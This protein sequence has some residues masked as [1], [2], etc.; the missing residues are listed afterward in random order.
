M[1][2]NGADAPADDVREAFAVLGNETRLAALWAIW[3]ADEE[4]VAFSDLQDAV[5]VADSGNLAYHLDRLT[6]RFVAQREDGYAL[7]PA[8]FYVVH[9]VTT[10]Y[11]ASA[12]DV[13]ATGIGDACPACG[14]ELAFS[15][16]D[17][18]A[19][20]S[21]PACSRVFTTRPL[22]P[23]AVASRDVAGAAAA[24]NA[25]LRSDYRRYLADVCS[26]CQ[27]PVERSMVPADGMAE[28]ELLA[29]FDESDGPVLC[30]ECEHCEAAG[31]VPAGVLL[32]WVPEAAAFLETHGVDVANATIWEAA[33]WSRDGG[34]W[35]DDDG[36]HVAVER[37][38]ECLHAT[39][40][41]DLAPA[42]VTRT[43]TA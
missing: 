30:F 7:L 34:A 17:T 42:S 1:D 9:I 31:E 21:C 6:G 36:L 14:S 43:R 25:E 20:V 32:F 13:E 39:F 12:T 15:Y 3:D 37:G 22:P 41:E 19:S 29:G 40:D 2:R 8:G 5:G 28:L 18:Y 27:A 23:M 33:A 24:L 38:R 16:L 35:V 10:G 26:F 4:T 11:L